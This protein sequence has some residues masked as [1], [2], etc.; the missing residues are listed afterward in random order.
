MVKWT[1]GNLIHILPQPLRRNGRMTEK[2]WHGCRW[3]KVRSFL[4]EKCTYLSS[5]HIVT[6]LQRDSQRIYAW[7]IWLALVR[8]PSFHCASYYLSSRNKLT[9]DALIGSRK[10]NGVAEVCRI[11][12]YQYCLS[13]TFKYLSDSFTA[14][15]S[16]LL[17]WKTSSSSTVLAS[18][19]SHREFH[20]SGVL[21]LC[22]HQVFERY[23]RQYVSSLE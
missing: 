19:F 12:A 13:L 10:V 1:L 18:T 6:S 8:W 17:F 5:Y 23:E 4:P 14:S 2:G 16:R 11:G 3:L 9:C 22:F 7:L 15:L 21:I 20:A